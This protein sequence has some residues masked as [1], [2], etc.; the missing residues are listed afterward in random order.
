MR[1]QLNVMHKLKSR[2]LNLLQIEKNN[3]QRNWYCGI[4]I[5]F[6]DIIKRR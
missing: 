4:D 2:Q 1:L 3:I 6:N 5:N